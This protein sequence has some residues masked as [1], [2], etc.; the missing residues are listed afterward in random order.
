VRVRVSGI[1]VV[2]M[3]RLLHA[4]A[5]RAL[6][7][8]LVARR[9]AEMG[10]RLWLVA[11]ILAACVAAFTFWQVRVPLD[12][13]LRHEGEPVA[14]IRLAI[15][16][17]GFALAG[18][19]LAAW[20]RHA[21]AA[22]PP[23]P[24][25]LAL[26]VEPARVEAH[27]AR[28]ARVPGLAVCVPAAAAWL[29]GFGLLGAG[30]LAALALGFAA[31]LALLL[32]LACAL[33]LALSAA[34]SGPAARLP[35]AWRALVSARTAAAGARPGTASFRAESRWGALARLDRAVS[36]RAGSPRARLGFA[37]VA[38]AASLAP[39]F[40]VREPLQARALAFAAFALACTEL[41]AWAA[42]RAAGDP[43]SA[44]RPLPLSLGDAWQA[45]ARP[46]LAALGL[47]LLAHALLSTPLP[48]LARLGI[49]LAWAIPALLLV[50]LGLHL[51]LSLAGRP[52]AAEN[53]HYAWLATAL[54]AS[55]TIPLLGWGVLIAAWAQATRRLP[56]WDRPEP[57]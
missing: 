1:I 52:G 29:A 53:L 39:W 27:L 31:A 41:G 5:F 3:T 22:R 19:A 36:L 32:R 17:G 6:G 38:L 21:L 37:L 8:R 18:G 49:P 11:A 12:G 51:G 57:A 48:P 13:V 40:S 55:I 34:A 2:R 54:V 14:T 42:W 50:L 24:E 43:A 33:A 30:A 15:V 35:A 26:P 47:V 44:V 4:T 45:R 25:W 23:G 20:R 9:A 10:L 56:R 7:R 46:L 28:E 16:L